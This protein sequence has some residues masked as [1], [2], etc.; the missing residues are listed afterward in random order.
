MKRAKRPTAL[1]PWL[2]PALVGVGLVAF[3]SWAWPP[4]DEPEP[5]VREGNERYARGE[6][7]VALQRF[8]AAPGD[9]VRNAGVHMN[10]GIARVRIA[11]PPNDAAVLP[12]LAPDA[13][14]PQNWQRAQ[15]EM[16]NT[17]RGTEGA[18]ADGARVRAIAPWTTWY[19][20]FPRAAE[21]VVD[22]GAWKGTQVFAE[23]VGP[24]HLTLDGASWEVTWYE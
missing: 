12:E 21:V 3:T 4:R 1:P 8:E 13:A 18:P 15:D 23:N 19:G 11:V 22:E 9:G 10:R 24:V 2:A 5:N 6:Y 17:A 7:P 16:R 14:L 20:T